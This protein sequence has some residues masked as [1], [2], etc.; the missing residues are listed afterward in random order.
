MLDRSC[1]SGNGHSDIGTERS[2]ALMRG[3]ICGRFWWIVTAHPGMAICHAEFGRSLCYCPVMARSVAAS[4]IS[5]ACGG[6]PGWSS[7]A[8][9]R[10]S[11][12]ASA[13]TCSSNRSCS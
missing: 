4:S 1:W 3:C 7:A 6:R 9:I 13:A 2:W 5:N 10:A 11:E 8:G 12:R